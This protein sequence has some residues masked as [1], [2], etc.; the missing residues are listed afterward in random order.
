L[1]SDSDPDQIRSRLVKRALR[2]ART[3]VHHDNGTQYCSTETVLLILPLLQ[4]NIMS[5]VWPSG[6]KE[7]LLE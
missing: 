6:G 7:E 1:T 3:I 4:T 2:N 5:Q